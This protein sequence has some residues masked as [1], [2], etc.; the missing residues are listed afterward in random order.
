MSREV[1]EILKQAKPDFIPGSA[2]PRP[3]CATKQETAFSG[4]VPKDLGRY[5]L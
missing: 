2:V 4:K 3:D 1:G 5:H